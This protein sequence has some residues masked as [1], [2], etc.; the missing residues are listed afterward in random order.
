MSLRGTRIAGLAVAA[1]ALS[2]TV[3]CGLIGGGDNDAACDAIQADIKQVTSD[4]LK[5]TSNLPG[6]E[7]VYHDGADKVRTDADKGS[8]DV[9]DAGHDVADELDKL[10]DFVKNISGDNTSMPD[11]SG[12][13]SAGAKLKTACDG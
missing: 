11:T 9:K 8:G 7:K 10:G 12:L 5:Q 4:G 6:L 2:T 3:G 13:N 1:L